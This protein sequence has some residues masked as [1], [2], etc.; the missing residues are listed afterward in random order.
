LRKGVTIWGGRKQDSFKVGSEV[1]RER[2][3]RGELR[4]GKAAQIIKNKEGLVEVLG[5]QS[6]RSIGNEGKRDIV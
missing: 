5:I 6:N 3:R 2:N 4:K 1:G